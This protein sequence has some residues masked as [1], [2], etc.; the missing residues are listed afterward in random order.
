[1][2][3]LWITN[4]STSVA[5]IV[6][7]L[8]AACEDGYHPTDIY[9]LENPA[10]EDVTTRATDLMKTIVTETGG[11]EPTITVKSLEDELDFQGIAAYLRTAIEA[12]Q[13]PDDQIAIDVTPGRRFWA[14][15][16][17]RAGHE[18][19]VDHLYYG[20]LLTEN[21][22]ETAYPAIPRTAMNL[23]DFTEAV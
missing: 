8:N 10:I 19:S 17:F 16:S 21:Y 23:I 13:G 14:I 7:T 22:Y 2:T 3:R 18:Y 9:L 15:I 6:N 12:A 4:G 11:D 5:P 20:H 1:M